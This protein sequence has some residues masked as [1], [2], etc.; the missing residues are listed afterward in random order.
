MRYNKIKSK[1]YENNRVVNSGIIIV[2][3]KKSEPSI[4]LLER[5]DHKHWEIPGGKV[6]LKDKI[7]KSKFDTLKDAAL[8]E[9]KEETGIYLKNKLSDMKPFYIDF[10]SPEGK[11]RRSYNFIAFSNKYPVL[12]KG[13]SDWEYIPISNLKKYK[14]APNVIILEKLIKKGLFNKLN[15]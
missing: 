6:E 1:F 9:V 14:L 8:R 12:E 11:K 10:I 2:N 7:N 4:L 3:H 5:K 15:K 13:F